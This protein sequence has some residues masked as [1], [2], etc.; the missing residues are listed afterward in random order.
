MLVIFHNLSGDG[1]ILNGKADE[2][3]NMYTNLL[4]DDDFSINFN[5]RFLYFLDADDIGVNKR[6]LELN[7]ILNLE[8]LNTS[9]LTKKDDFEFGC[10]IF[11]DKNN[12]NF[13][14][15]LE[16]VLLELMEKDNEGI[17]K[18]SKTYIDNN[19]FDSKFE[20]R[21][22]K[23]INENYKGSLQFKKQ[24]STISVA[25]QLQF[26]GSSNAV[27]IANT[28]YIKEGKIKNSSTCNEI[29]SLFYLE[30]K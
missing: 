14:G 4:G 22:K 12:K 26:S 16:D 2:V 19:A 5:F 1:N 21:Q 13:E 20:K 11:Y 15:N 17:F 24:K 23:F 8:N 7:N 10:Y 30:N 9:K 29:I 6:V 27:I 28:D 25:G 3:T 18:N